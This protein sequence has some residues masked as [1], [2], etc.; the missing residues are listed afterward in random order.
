MCKYPEC[1]KLQKVAEKSNECGHFFDWLIH[2]GYAN[3]K[4]RKRM[5]ELLAEYFEI[6]L[7]KVEKERQAMLD[8]IRKGNK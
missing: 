4:S 6:D 8:D 5:E 2:K 3:N 1:E 7:T